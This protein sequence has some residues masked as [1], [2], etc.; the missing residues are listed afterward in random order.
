MLRIA[1]PVD[2][3][4]ENCNIFEHFGRAPFYV[5][6]DV[7]NNEILN[8]ESFPNPSVSDH[9]PGEIPSTLASK[10]VNVLICMGVGKRA[11]YHFQNLG[12]QV[13]TGARGKIKE[14]IESYLRNEL[15][16]KP[17]EPDKKWHEHKY[18]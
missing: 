11:I 9:T 4:N 16:S 8:V 15:V 12:I 13:I 18:D 14:V 2:R 10:G 17:Y 6:I 7:E 5:I 1:V 3:N